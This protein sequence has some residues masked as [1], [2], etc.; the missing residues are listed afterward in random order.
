MGDKRASV[1]R[2]GEGLRVLV[3][4]DTTVRECVVLSSILKERGTE[5]SLSFSVLI[6]YQQTLLRLRLKDNWITMRP[7]SRV[8]PELTHT[9]ADGLR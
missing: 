8:R 7:R 3:P 6:K 1:E 2:H 5:G 9:H 4:A